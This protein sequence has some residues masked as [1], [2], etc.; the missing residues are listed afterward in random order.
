M[1]EE[2]TQLTLATEELHI[3]NTELQNQLKESETKI[4]TLRQQVEDLPIS[5]SLQG[6]ERDH[7]AIV[8][9]NKIDRK[10]ETSQINMTKIET[11]ADEKSSQTD[12][13]A[14]MFIEVGIKLPVLENVFGEKTN[15]Q[16]DTMPT[17]LVERVAALEKELQLL[18][19]ENAELTEKLATRSDD[20]SDEDELF[21]SGSDQR[22]KDRVKSLERQL[23]ILHAENIRLGDRLVGRL[24]D[25]GLDRD[26]LMQR[27]MELE[28]VSGDLQ[29][30]VQAAEGYERQL[31][32]KLRLAEQTIN[33]LESSEA[34]YRDRCDELVRRENETKKQL[35]AL[36]TTGQELREIILDKDIV[37]QALR[38]KVDKFVDLVVPVSSLQNDV[39]TQFWN[40]ASCS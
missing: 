31:R 6:E 18:Q 37:E 32:D 29:E 10:R 3:K 25:D 38:E 11:T 28:D 22:L 8:G 26:E 40:D 39:P 27:M 23:Q 5:S 34:Q 17:K 19:E 14:P 35:Q 15:L 33:E 21:K 30:R 20:S 7:S 9:F 2:I 16:E 12:T 13:E 4:V 1:Q 24:P 36:Q